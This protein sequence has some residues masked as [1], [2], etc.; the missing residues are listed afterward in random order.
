M[1]LQEMTKQTRAS[2]EI[3]KWLRI[4]FITKFWLRLRIRVRKKNANS[5]RSRLRHCGSMATS[6][7]NQK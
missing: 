5:C 3:E 1:F 6:E 4:R 2:A 7:V